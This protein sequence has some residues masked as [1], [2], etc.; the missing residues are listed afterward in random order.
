MFLLLR[1][2]RSHFPTDIGTVVVSVET[3]QRERDR[4]D[5]AGSE[6][7]L[8]DGHHQNSAF[9][10]DIVKLRYDGDIDLERV[11]RSRAFVT[12]RAVDK[13]GYL[14]GGH[15]RLDSFVVGSDDD[16]FVEIGKFG[17]AFVVGAFQDFRRLNIYRRRK[18]KQPDRHTD[19]RESDQQRRDKYLVYALFLCLGFE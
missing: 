11:Y 18:R 5:F 13:H 8:L 10:K 14:A 4:N 7:A 12:D 9:A 16:V 2:D 17:R 1:P 19:N 3:I 15:W 6:N